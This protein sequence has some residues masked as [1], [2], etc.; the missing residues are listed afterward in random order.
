VRVD[1]GKTCGSDRIHSR[2]KGDKHTK[3]NVFRFDLGET[4]SLTTDLF[5]YPRLVFSHCESGRSSRRSNPL[6]GPSSTGSSLFELPV[7]SKIKTQSKEIEAISLASSSA[8]FPLDEGVS[9]E[10]LQTVEELT[11]SRFDRRTVDSRRGIRF[12]LTSASILSVISSTYGDR[13]T[14][15]WWEPTFPWST[16]HLTLVPGSKPRPH[17][18]RILGS[19]ILLSLLPGSQAMALCGTKHIRNWLLAAGSVF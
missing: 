13:V 1:S 10:A 6:K 19:W 3:Q 18:V 12:R 5:S 11:E 9:R 7:G 15:D 2:E 17:I 16:P 14:R 8:S 4:T